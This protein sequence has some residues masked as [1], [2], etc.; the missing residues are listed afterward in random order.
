MTPAPVN[1]YHMDS[2]R[3]ARFFHGTVGKNWGSH[4][5]PGMSKWRRERSIL[6][7]GGC[8]HVSF[9]DTWYPLAIYNTRPFCNVFRYYGLRFSSGPLF[10]S[11]RIAASAQVLVPEAAKNP[12]LVGE[13]W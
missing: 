6:H 2:Y 1:V 13:K 8:S 4:Q 11:V 7:G 5:H 12:T 9:P 10:W 3:S